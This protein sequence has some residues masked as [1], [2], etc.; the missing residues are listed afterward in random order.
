MFIAKSSS[1]NACLGVILSRVATLI[2]LVV[3]VGRQRWLAVVAAAAA[4]ASSEQVASAC[5]A[6]AA[7][8]AAAGCVCACRS[9]A[10][11]EQWQ[12]LDDTASSPC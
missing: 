11:L 1:T 2:G 4:A 9:A 5:C 6:T 12:T 3:K 8:A 10:A 7:H